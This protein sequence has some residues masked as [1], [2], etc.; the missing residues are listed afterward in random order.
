MNSLQSFSLSLNLPIGT[1]ELQRDYFPLDIDLSKAII[2]LNTFEDA[3]KQSRVYDYIQDVIDFSS[4]ELAQNGYF[5]FQPLT[6]KEINYRCKNSIYNLTPNQ[7]AHLIDNCALV[8]CSDSMYSH[9]ANEAG[10]KT[11]CLFGPSSVVG[12]SPK[13]NPELFFPI[14]ES[15]SPPSYRSVESSKSVNKNKVESIIGKIYSV[16]ALS[17]KSTVK[18][19]HIGNNYPVNFIELVPDSVINPENFKDKILTVRMDYLFNEDIL[20]EILSSRRCNIISEKPI[21][22]DLIKKYKTSI[23]NFNLAI[24]CD[25]DIKYVKDLLKI[26]IKTIFFSYEDKVNLQKTRM[27]FFDLTL[28]ESFEKPSRVKS[29]EEKISENTVFRTNNFLL[30]DGKIFTSFG[31]WKKGESIPSFGQNICKFDIDDES[32]WETLEFCFIFDLTK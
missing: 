26:G 10:K 12:H 3:K 31:K 9:V 11:I 24:S 4:N 21:N 18:T 2:I 13:F 6:G 1:P 28:V 16:L 8:L 23:I 20:A 27:K 29:V 22:L 19:I 5:F 25:T 32:I 17:N 15:D 7:I 14:R 30:S